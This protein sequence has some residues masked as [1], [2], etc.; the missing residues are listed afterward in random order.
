[1]CWGFLVAIWCV[2]NSACEAKRNKEKEGTE[3]TS[4]SLLFKLD[5]DAVKC[6]C[7]H[8]YRLKTDAHVC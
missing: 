5:E 8:I 7:A 4:I 2:C 6:V 1:M 3:E